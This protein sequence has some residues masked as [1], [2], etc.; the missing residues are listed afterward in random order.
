MENKAA[1]EIK[2]KCTRDI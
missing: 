1:V 2:K